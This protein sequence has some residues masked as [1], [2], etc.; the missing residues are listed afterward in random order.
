VDL[1]PIAL[2]ENLVH[3][4]A[5][6][7]VALGDQ[8]AHAIADV[9]AEACARHRGDQRDRPPVGAQ[10]R[11]QPRLVGAQA[12]QRRDRALELFGVGGEQLVLRERVEQRD[13]GLVVMGAFDQVQPRQDLRE[14]AVQQRRTARRLRVGLAGEQPDHAA[15][16]AERHGVHARAAVHRRQLGGLADPQPAPLRHVAAREA[17]V[18]PAADHPE[19][20]E[21]PLKQPAQER[22]IVFVRDLL[23]EPLDARGHLLEVGDDALHGA[24]HVAHLVLELGQLAGLEPPVDLEVHDRLAGQLARV[25]HAHDVALGVALDADDRVRVA[26]DV[27]PTRGKYL[28]HGV[29]EERQVGRVRLDQRPA[30]ARRG[31]AHRGERPV[32]RLGH[33]EGVPDLGGD[34]VGGRRRLGQPT[35]EVGASEGDK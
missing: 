30:R 10:P 11:Q 16:A 4:D 31:G 23:G 34:V 9:G 25:A 22:G 32:A 20:H 33:R 28:P 21:V 8:V 19:Q 27:Q 2:A 15:D 13:R 26:H 6:R 3:V 1:H 7:P 35:T 29:D 17:E 14:L 12:E 18:R 24:E 5:V